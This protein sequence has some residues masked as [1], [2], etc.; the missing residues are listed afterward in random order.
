MG[1][2]KRIPA[3]VVGPQIN[4][5]FRSRQGLREAR[6]Y[7]E[8]VVNCDVAKALNIKIVRVI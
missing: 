4:V 2:I 6:P 8:F 1:D 5:P 3:M 7:I